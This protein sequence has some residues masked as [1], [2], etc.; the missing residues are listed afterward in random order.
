MEIEPWMAIRRHLLRRRRK[1][2]GRISRE[3]ATA[4]F[5]GSHEPKAPMTNGRVRSRQLYFSIFLEC[6]ALRDSGA[7]KCDF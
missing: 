4:L 3:A 5:D 2:V 6:Q 7:I 1:G